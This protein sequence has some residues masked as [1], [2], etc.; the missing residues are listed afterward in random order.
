MYEIDGLVVAVSVFFKLDFATNVA[1]TG[2]M[3]NKHVY[4]SN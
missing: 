2:L 4:V 3:S 1:Q